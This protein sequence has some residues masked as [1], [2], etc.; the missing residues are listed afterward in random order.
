MKTE[1][2][3]ISFSKGINQDVHPADMPEGSYFE[4]EGVITSSNEGT[5][6]NTFAIQNERGFIEYADFKVKKP[7][8]LIM[9]MFAY[10][11]RI[12]IC[13]ISASI[14]GTVVTTIESEIGYIEDEI[15]VE[16][17]NDSDVSKNPTLSENFGFD[18][19]YPI[20]GRFKPN[21]KNELVFYWVDQGLNPPRFLNLD[22]DYTDANNQFVNLSQQTTTFETIDSP[23]VTYVSTIE[24]GNVKPGLYHFAV[25]YLNRT[26]DPT[27]FGLLCNGIPVIDDGREVSRLYY[28][29]A[30]YQAGN[31]SKALELEIT[32]IDKD[33]FYIEVAV[34]TYVGAASTPSAFI[35]KRERITP[36][37]PLRIIFDGRVGESIPFALLTESKPVYDTAKHI[38]TKDN[39]LL[40]ADLS[41]NG[42]VNLQPIAN[43]L[44]LKYAITEIEWTENYCVTNS[45]PE[46]GLSEYDDT[47]ATVPENYEAAGGFDDYKN[48]RLT[49]NQKSYG[50]DECYSFAIVGILAKGGFT[51]S[52]HIPGYFDSIASMPESGEYDNNASTYT[53]SGDTTGYLNCFVSE[54]KYDDPNQLYYFDENG[55]SLHGEFIRHHLFPTHAQEPH[56]RVDTGV[57]TWIRPMGVTIVGLDLALA[58]YPEIDAKLA[59][60]ILVREQRNTF[61]NKR[62]YGMG[63]INRMSHWNGSTIGTLVTAGKFDLVPP[64]CTINPFFGDTVI[65]G[66]NTSFAQCFYGQNDP[67]NPEIIKAGA[68]FSPESVLTTGFTVPTSARIIPISQLDSNLRECITG[69]SSKD[70]EVP[71]YSTTSSA[72]GTYQIATALGGTVNSNTTSE[73]PLIEDWES[74]LAGEWSFGTYDPAS[75]TGKLPRGFKYY[76]FADFNR[77]PLT[78]YSN[79]TP[80]YS[81]NYNQSNSVRRGV[82]IKRSY[83]TSWNSDKHTAVGIVTLPHL[84][85]EKYKLN[86]YGSEGF[87]LIESSEQIP[88]DTPN[89]TGY[90]TPA[91]TPIGYVSG[92]GPY[93]NIKDFLDTDQHGANPEFYQIRV[94]IELKNISG[95]ASPQVNDNDFMVYVSDGLDPIAVRNLNI[96]KNVVK[97]QYKQLD[98]NEYIIVDTFLKY[99]EARQELNEDE[100]LVPTNQ[101]DVEETRTA[102]NGDVF[103]SKFY[104]KNSLTIPYGFYDYQ[105]TPGIWEAD[106]PDWDKNSLLDVYG[107]MAPELQ[108][109]K[110]GVLK[111]GNYYFV[112]SEINCNYRHFPVERDELGNITKHGVPYFPK[113]NKHKVLSPDAELGQSNGY[114]INYSHENDLKKF[115]LRPFGFEDVV[116]YPNR[117]IASEQQFEGEASDQWRQFFFNTYQDIPKNNGA[118]TSIFV[119]RNTLYAHVERSLYRMFFNEASIVPSSTQEILL[120]NAG[121]FSRPASEMYVVGNNGTHAGYCG[122]IHKF[123]NV[124]TPFGRIIVDYYQKKVFLFTDTISEISQNGLWKWW[125]NIMKFT[126]T[127]PSNPNYLVD[128][129]NPF[130]A[131]IL[132]IYDPEHKRVIIVFRELEEFYCRSF[133]LLN[134]AWV[135]LHHYDPHVAVVFDTKIISTQNTAIDT[136]L[137]LHD[138]G[139][140]GVFYDSEVVHESSITFVS[141]VN[142]FSDKTFDNFEV[143]VEFYDHSTGRLV[144]P[145]FFN[146]MSFWS[147]HQYT[148]VHPVVLTDVDNQFNI[149]VVRSQNHYNLKTPLSITIDESQPVFDPTNQDALLED[150]PRMRGTFLYGKFTYNNENNFHFVLNY[151]FSNFRISRR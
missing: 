73:Y 18:I 75:E 8:H 61:S 5:N 34:L 94:A 17:L 144:K 6:G 126:G 38:D 55:N 13:S 47:E 113:Q 80:Y 15:Y 117:V 70:H 49:F 111:A 90:V 108:D 116:E 9:G 137:A 66:I 100:E 85:L 123:A 23:I 82:P 91:G 52:F 68:W 103:I 150:K 37:V 125:K 22:L 60:I 76:L 51:E 151:I 10:G 36:T 122:S 39:R 132:T 141:R 87:L 98:G 25:R 3:D 1:N 78:Y 7:D 147:D 16:V 69:T 28:D 143:F 119:H 84:V 124:N 42:M 97:N 135:S 43:M 95:S 46:Y 104:Y 142:R 57:A 20:D 64:T 145:E 146:T 48:E 35:I 99:D 118:I 2:P 129:I 86:N 24:G 41:L 74:P 102:Y 83:N 96:I 53:G 93:T 65:E 56:Y 106:Y 112:E 139:N 149:N 128:H 110:G 88:T 133:S 33:F 89:D 79:D 50:R 11:K 114:N 71:N 14:A 27:T 138:S 58:A 59:G 134:N 31:T 140:Y 127:D 54:D 72:Y 63:F 148:G 12:V 32:N 136:K 40:Y 92:F 109:R 121:V 107:P 77:E 44:R 101:L 67:L 21:Y 105:A 29:G 45:T 19:R 130:A 62:V 4:A 30:D 115:F 131:G 26:L 81:A 120:G